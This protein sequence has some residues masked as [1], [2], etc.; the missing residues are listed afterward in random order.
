M[1][2]QA[3]L[4]WADAWTW[5]AK[6]TWSESLAIILLLFV[7]AMIVFC[8]DIVDAEFGYAKKET[9]TKSD[10]ARKL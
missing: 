5:Q 9:E 2:E 7:L 4:W 1:I 10:E 3:R 6:L 8:W